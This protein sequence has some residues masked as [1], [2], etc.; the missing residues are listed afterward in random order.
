MRINNKLAAASLVALFSTNSVSDPRPGNN[1]ASIARP[2]SVTQETFRFDPPQGTFCTTDGHLAAVNIFSATNIKITI[3]AELEK[4][5]PTPEM[6]AAMNKISLLPSTELVI[7]L[8]RDF[9][10]AEIT[11]KGMPL[12]QSF[13]DAWRHRIESQSTKAGEIDITLTQIDTGVR[14]L[15]SPKPS[16][17]C[18]AIQT[19]SV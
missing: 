19:L 7:S 5:G 14:V 16:K 10:S 6:D 1:A 18:G 12:I 2:P 15:V 3:P 9:S 4:N 13:R 8:L 17:E 11:E